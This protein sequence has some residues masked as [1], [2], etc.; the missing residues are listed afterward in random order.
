MEELEHRTFIVLIENRG[1]LI[2]D[3]IHVVLA[4]IVA[5]VPAVRLA[6]RIQHSKIAI[7]TAVFLLH[8]D[9]MA[10]GRD[11]GAWS[12]GWRCRG[13][14]GSGWGWGWGWGWGRSCRWCRRRCW[15]RRRCGG[16]R[17]SW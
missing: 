9:Y 1:Q 6:I 2:V 12:R 8:Q 11:T 16:W 10:D 17:R 15:T 3:S 14:W 5:N 7:K 4:L 13:N